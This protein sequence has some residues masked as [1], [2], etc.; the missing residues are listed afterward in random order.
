MILKADN[1]FYTEDVLSPAEANFMQTQ[2]VML[3]IV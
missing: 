1:V 2:N 3:N